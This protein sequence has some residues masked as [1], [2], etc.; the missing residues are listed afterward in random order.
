VDNRASSDLKAS[1]L[2]LLALTFV[3]RA[4]GAEEEAEV[5]GPPESQTSDSESETSSD[6]QEQEG[7]QDEAAA[8]GEE[9]DT[10]LEDPVSEEELS[11]ESEPDR[12]GERTALTDASNEAPLEEQDDW[13]KW[14]FTRRNQEQERHGPHR[15]MSVGGFVG[16]VHR[17]SQTSAIRYRPGIAWGGYVRPELASWLGLR[18]FYREERLP[19][20]VEPGAFDYG[21]DTYTDDFEQQDL[22]VLN[23][24]ARLEPTLV[25]HPRVRMRGIF[26]WS[27]LWFQVPYPRS[28]TFE[29]KRTYRSAVQMDFTFGAGFS[30]DIIENWV[31]ISMD[32]SY[33]VPAGQTGSAYEPSQIVRDGRIRHIGELPRLQNSV[34]VLISLGVIL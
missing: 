9:A 2:L 24:G 32:A 3:T 14:P 30:L 19:V 33:S 11:E 1:T 5:E 12:S 26:G 25:L 21:D 27:W 16:W 6:E 34:D 4:V 23:I 17:P 22:E 29:L 18:L 20:E 8:E 31:D 28:E 7:Q 10:P 13:L 15:W